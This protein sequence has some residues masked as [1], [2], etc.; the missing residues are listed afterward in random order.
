MTTI[1]DWCAYKSGISGA[2]IKLFQIPFL[3]SKRRGNLLTESLFCIIRK[4]KMLGV[5]YMKNFVEFLSC[6]SI[7]TSLTRGFVSLL[8]KLRSPLFGCTNYG[9][10]NWRTLTLAKAW[11]VLSCGYTRFKWG[12]SIAHL[13]GVRRTASQNISTPQGK[14]LWFQA[15]RIPDL[16]KW[17]TITKWQ[18]RVLLASCLIHTVTAN[19]QSFL[20]ARGVRLLR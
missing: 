14:A 4:Y 1:H 20:M 12:L 19:L 8:W 16:P 2:R 6:S 3:A 15:A 13:T 18:S 10:K 11:L 17:S 5:H 9:W 7:F